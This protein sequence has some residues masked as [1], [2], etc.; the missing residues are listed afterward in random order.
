MPVIL[1]NGSKEWGGLR[2]EQN[3]NMDNISPLKLQRILLDSFWNAYGLDGHKHVK[4]SKP[5]EDTLEALRVIGETVLWKH[6]KLTLDKKRAKWNKVKN[7]R[8]RFASHDL[9]FVCR[10]K[11]EIRHHIIWLSNGGLNSKRNII[12]LCKFCHAEIHPWL[13]LR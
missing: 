7:S 9:C 1:G 8:H 11:G 2:G 13:K 6:K 3:T 12:T 5:K 4:S 10:S